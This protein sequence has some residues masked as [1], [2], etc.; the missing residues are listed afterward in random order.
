MWQSRFAI[1]RGLLIAGAISLSVVSA[2]AQ[3][4][5]FVQE[6]RVGGEAL[7]G[8][9]LEQAASA[10]E[11]CTAL[12]PAF[13]EAWFNLGLVRLQQH[14][15]GDAIPLFEKSLKLKPGL[16]GANLFLRSEEHTSELQSL[17]HLVC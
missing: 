1:R 6:F 13:A 11:R 10:F 2:L 16:R 3:S 9:R 7:R 17:R 5:P 15:I 12:D 14:K 8:G 4:E